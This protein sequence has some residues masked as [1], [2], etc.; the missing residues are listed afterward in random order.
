MLILCACVET[1][2][3]VTGAG[4]PTVSDAVQV[5]PGDGLPDGL[6]VQPAN[7]NLDVADHA[8][9]RWLA[10]RTGPS[11]F[12]SPDV[13]LHVISSEDEHTWREETSFAFGTDLREPRLLAWHDRLWLYFAELGADAADFEPVGA[14]VSERLADGSWTTAVRVYEDGFIPWRARVID[15]VPYVM[16]YV[17]G[18]N[19]YDIDGEPIRVHWLT[20]TDGVTLEP[21]LPGQPV[22]HEGGA[23][24]T[25]FA[26]LGDGGLVAV[27]R[28]EAGEDDAWG[29][30]VCRAGSGDLGSWDCVTDPK[31]YDSPLVFQ[32]DGR[33]WLIGRRNLSEDGAYDL[34]RDDL[35]AAEQTAYYQADYWVHPKRCSLWEVDPA[36]R[37]VRFV[38]DLPSRGDTC[39]ASV[40]PVSERVLAVYNYS[41]PLDGDDVAWVQGQQG[42]THI[43]RVELSFP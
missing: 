22:V 35:S 1:E 20:T 36:D 3:P 25:D 12:A 9:R 28:N 8:G 7:N 17:G 41:S 24:E 18:E 43:Y 27:M 39:F 34:G 13:V 5:V 31:K 14:W 21:V 30:L 42:P 10:F 6:E 15:G 23:S 37:T 2:E 11:H 19:I 16:G 38:L 33:T 26:F 40:A 32:Q 29:S 4:D